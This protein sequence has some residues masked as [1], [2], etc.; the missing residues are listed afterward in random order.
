MKVSSVESV[1]EVGGTRRR[2]ASWRSYPLTLQSM[3]WSMRNDAPD[4]EISERD[5][6]HHCELSAI[7][8]MEDGLLAEPD[9]K[10]TRELTGR[11]ANPYSGTT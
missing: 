5:S 1:Q 3:T 8:V 11:T 6:G 10:T 9:G 7:E 4:D 2:G